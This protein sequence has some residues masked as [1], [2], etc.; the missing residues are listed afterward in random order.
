MTT[1]FGIALIAPLLWALSTLLDKGLLAWLGEDENDTEPVF[2]LILYSMLFSGIAAPILFFW[3]QGAILVFESWAILFLIIAGIADALAVILFLFTL[4]REDATIVAPFSQTIPIFG[5]IF[6]MLFLSEFL[7][8]TQILGAAIIVGGSMLITAD[9][10]AP[11]K[12]RAA[13]IAMALAAAA[14]FAAFDTLF[15]LAASDEHYWGALFW[16][17]I[18]LLL[19]GLCI[20]LFRPKERLGFIHSIRTNGK[21]LFSLNIFNEI[22]YAA[23]VFLLAWALLRAPIALVSTATAYQPAFVLLGSI[24]LSYLLPR[25]FNERVEMKNMAFRAFAIVLV[26]LGG[27]IL[28]L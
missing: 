2:V 12:A 5:F 23:G 15:K 8:L 27:I 26:V 6:G 3:A 25:Y 13:T 14:S 4:E 22:L 20:V 17:H 19:V 24:V 28:N 10:R 21:L 11:F 16:V 9:S 7:T 18:G 1:W